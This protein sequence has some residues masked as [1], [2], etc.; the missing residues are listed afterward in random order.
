N[1]TT[2]KGAATIGLGLAMVGA[3][4]LEN[5]DYLR[6]PSKCGTNALCLFGHDWPLDISA[7]MKV[8]GKMGDD[9]RNLPLELKGAE[10]GGQFYL[11]SPCK[12]DIILTQSKCE[13]REFYDADAFYSDIVIEE[14]G[15]ELKY[16][17]GV[18]WFYLPDI[19]ETFTVE[20]KFQPDSDYIFK[21][22]GDTPITFKYAPEDDE[23]NSKTIKLEDGSPIKD[24]L[25][26]EA[27][28]RSMDK[29]QLNN[30]VLPNT[31]YT[32]PLGA[33]N[34]YKFSRMIRH[35]L[36][37]GVNYKKCIKGDWWNFW[38]DTDDVDCIK[39]ELKGYGDY[40]PNFCF[41][42]KW[43]EASRAEAA[44][45]GTEMVVGAAAAI[46]ASP[47]GPG[48]VAAYCGASMAI[49]TA[50][51]WVLAGYM[52]EDKWPNGINQ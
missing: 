2:K 52:A 16:I 44:L 21:Y 31:D 33:A 4:K 47:T 25:V 8:Q 22:D 15:L 14:W 28:L 49:S 38:E 51:A 9:A 48:A 29:D 10:N 45:F 50:G 3:A 1:P 42:K 24:P 26:L 17:P 7:D 37:Q 23:K 34:G 39:V 32:E 30:W 11:A 27:A 36:E 6:D 20:A 18:G 12:A 13:C 46:L 43:D 41:E 19:V 5:M 35:N 40:D